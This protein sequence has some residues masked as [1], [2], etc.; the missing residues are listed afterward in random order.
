MLSAVEV[1]AELFA[2]WPSLV[3]L[4]QTTG[5]EYLLPSICFEVDW[6]WSQQLMCLSVR[7][8]FFFFLIKTS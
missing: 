8:A 5:G 3:H 4:K 1:R 7:K 6:G 2:Q